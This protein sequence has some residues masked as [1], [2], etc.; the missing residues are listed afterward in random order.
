MQ[1]KLNDG[2]ILIAGYLGKD[3]EYRQVG[4]KNSSLT[5]FSVMV[6]KRVGSNEAIW[7]SCECWHE[8]ARAAASLKKFDVVMC[9]G[10]IETKNYTDSNGQQKKDVH[11]VVEG[12]FVQPKPEPVSYTADAAQMLQEIDNSSDTCP[13]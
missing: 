1:T 9:F 4:E 5:K 3:A 7:V 2:S 12:V 11:L 10:H 8:V 13:F 6:G